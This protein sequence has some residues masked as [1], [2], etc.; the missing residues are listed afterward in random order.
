[1]GASLHRVFG[2][3][4]VSVSGLSHSELSWYK[5][6][7]I[8]NH[9]K[10]QKRQQGGKKKKGGNP[11]SCISPPQMEKGERRRKKSGECY[12]SILNQSPWSHFSICSRIHRS[13]FTYIKWHEEKVPR[14]KAT[15]SKCVSFHMF[16]CAVNF[17]RI[18]FDCYF[19]WLEGVGRNPPK[20]L[21]YWRV[22]NCKC[23]G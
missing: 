17:I 7:N 9:K 18:C 4:A 3:K 5:G 8:I 15:R 12:F 16:F 20:H 22:K 11:Y 19:M 6:A 1:M 10:I 2:A 14:G 13:K 21:L 23:Y